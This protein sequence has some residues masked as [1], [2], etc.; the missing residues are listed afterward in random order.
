MPADPI[1]IHALYVEDDAIVTEQLEPRQKLY[2]LVCTCSKSKR[3]GWC[4]H[5]EYALTNRLDVAPLTRAGVVKDDDERQPYILPDNG[6]LEVP[7]FHRPHDVAIL[8]ALGDP[9]PPTN[10][11]EV[12]FCL[13]PDDTRNMDLSV[14]FLPEGAS[15]WDIRTLV[16]EWLMGQW[17]TSHDALICQ[18]PQHTLGSPYENW[19]SHMDEDAR[20]TN[21]LLIDHLFLVCQ[22]QC[23]RCVEDNGVP[24]IF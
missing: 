2:H 3:K 12:E 9:I 11:R 1:P 8:A 20:P 16:V 4:S 24:D 21:H 7:L 22:Q 18:A 5:I 6:F 15:R 19:Q 13:H 14:G 10:F 23:F 17:I